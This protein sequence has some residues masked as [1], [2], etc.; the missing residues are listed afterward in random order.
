MSLAGRRMSYNIRAGRHRKAR[1]DQL[2]LVV[3]SAPSRTAT[4]VRR[5]V[6]VLVLVLLVR[7]ST[8][9]FPSALEGRPAPTHAA[10]P[11]HS[12]QASVTRVRCLQTVNTMLGKTLAGIRSTSAQRA[13][14]TRHT[15]FTTVPC[16]ISPTRSL[17]SSL[18]K[19]SN[20]CR[21]QS[22]HTM[23]R[24]GAAP[25]HTTAHSTRTAV[26]I[27]RNVSFTLKTTRNTVVPARVPVSLVHTLRSRQ[28]VNSNTKCT[29]V[30]SHAK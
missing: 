25:R 28:C 24:Q 26:P 30:L 4:I 2:G 8:P 17:P 19:S 15:E 3:A 5:S 12:W 21:K 14:H 11:S 27:R 29:N 6:R 13:K 18:R 9:P 7:T 20:H 22:P 23:P 10:I 1:E 16:D